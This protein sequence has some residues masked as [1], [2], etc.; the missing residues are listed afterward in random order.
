VLREKTMPLNDDDVK[1]LIRLYTKEEKAINEVARHF[2]IAN[3]TVNYW[4]KKNNIAKRAWQVQFGG[5]A[6]SK[7]DPKLLKRYDLTREQ[8]DSMCNK[9]LG[10]V[11]SLPAEEQPFRKK[12]SQKAGT[13]EKLDLTDAMQWLKIL[14]DIYE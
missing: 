14:D 2:G 3:T 11:Y 9:A 4:L 10:Q 5:K 7:S 13:W 6:K 8:F 12:V 1:E